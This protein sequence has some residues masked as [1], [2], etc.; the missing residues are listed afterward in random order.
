LD[1]SYRGGPIDIEEIEEFAALDEASFTI[2]CYQA[3]SQ[4][5]ITVKRSRIIEAA[6]DDVLLQRMDK[7]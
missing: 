4:A 3:Q 6:V 7:V 2:R 1:F 5:S